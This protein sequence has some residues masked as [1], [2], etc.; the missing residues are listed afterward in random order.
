MKQHTHH[1]V[2]RSRGGSDDQ[3]NLQQM[4]FIEHAHLHAIDFLNGGPRFDFRHEGWP[5]LDKELRQQVLE[6]ASEH[7]RNISGPAGAATLTFEQ[8]SKGGK[9]GGPIGARN[10]PRETRVENGKK[11]AQTRLERHGTY[12]K[13]RHE[14]GGK[15]FICPSC[16]YINNAGNVAKH[17]KSQKNNCVGEKQLIQTTEEET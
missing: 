8:L 7:S 17:L 15:E 13:V 10:Q 5:F 9:K 3:S 2:P 4:D 1:K 11:G 6:K 16:G 12:F 14:F